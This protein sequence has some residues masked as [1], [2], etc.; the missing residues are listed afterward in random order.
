MM[1]KFLEL[2][3]QSIIVQ[4]LITALVIGA[5]VYLI[6]TGQEVPDT[7]GAVVTTVLGFWFGSKAGYA[8]GAR[9]MR[10]TITKMKGE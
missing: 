2:L 8:Q 7:F 3:E 5:Y 10:A 6:A 1:T 9:A 4:S